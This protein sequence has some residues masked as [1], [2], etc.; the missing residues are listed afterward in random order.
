VTHDD[1][2]FRFRVRLFGL[3]TE[4]GNVRAACRMMGV[5]H[6]TFYRWRAQLER[7][8]PEILR[9]RER[10]QPR[11]A[12]AISPMVEQRVIAFSLGHP[13]FGPKRIAAVLARPLWGGLCLSPNGVWRILRGH[14]LSTRARRLGLICGYAA[15]PEPARPQPEPRHLE[16]SRPGE[17]LQLDCFYVGRLSGSSGTVWQYTAID[18]ASSYVWAELHLSERNPRSQHASALARRA[19]AELAACGWRLERVLTDNA[20]EVRNRAFAETIASLGALQRFI[21]AGR[22]QSNGCVERVQQ[23]ILDGCWKPAFARF[24]I[25][26]YTGL[27]RD[28]E[29]YLRYYNF[30]RAHTGRWNQGR[31][32]AQVL[33]TASC[34]SVG[35]V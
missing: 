2:L 18:V 35:A 26:K 27:R 25:P 34:Y 17:L 4:L 10:R 9:P 8:G 3:A 12:N 21:A 30:D 6:S 24:L 22:P 11:M 5:H 28:L 32:P 23:T 20:C 13:G 1:A 19:A 7:F 33:G 16:V 14:G 15:P 31:T 29:R